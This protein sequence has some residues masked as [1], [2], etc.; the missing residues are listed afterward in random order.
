[1]KELEFN[2]LDKLSNN[3][4][5]NKLAENAQKAVKEMQTPV[6]Q[7]GIPEHIVPPIIKKQMENEKK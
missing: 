3:E 2:T 7:V 5:L 6:S 1:M 4:N